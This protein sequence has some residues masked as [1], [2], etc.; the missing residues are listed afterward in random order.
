ML[1]VLGGL[2][3]TTGG[4]LV[5]AAPSDQRTVFAPPTAFSVQPTPLFGN[6]LAGVGVSGRF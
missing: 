5:L 4:V 6:G 3:Q 2:A 1:L